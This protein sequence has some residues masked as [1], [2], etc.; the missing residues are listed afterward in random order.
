VLSTQV[1]QMR[2]LRLYETYIT[3][4]DTNLSNTKLATTP[5]RRGT[6]YAL[7]CYIL[8]THKKKSFK[9]VVSPYLHAIFYITDEVC[10]RRK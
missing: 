8:T 9:K 1:L 4:A 10:A 2:L 7:Y 5:R 3:A 6:A